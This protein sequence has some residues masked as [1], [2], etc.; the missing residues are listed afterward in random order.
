MGPGLTS[1]AWYFHSPDKKALQAINCCGNKKSH[2]DSFNQE[3]TEK[4]VTL[5]QGAIE[6]MGYTQYTGYTQ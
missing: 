2:K 3:A 1:C 5:N 6:A 4:R